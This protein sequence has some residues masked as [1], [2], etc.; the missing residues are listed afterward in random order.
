MTQQFAVGH[1][2]CD[3]RSARVGAC[4]ICPYRTE[5]TVRYPFAIIFLIPHPRLCALLTFYNA[6]LTE[7]ASVTGKPLDIHPLVAQLDARDSPK[8]ISDLL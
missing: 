5:T 7:Y 6:A 3:L 4:V 2:A 8:A 1:R